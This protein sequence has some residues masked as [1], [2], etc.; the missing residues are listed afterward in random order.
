MQ[1]CELD[2]TTLQSRFKNARIHFTIV[3]TDPFTFKGFGLCQSSGALACARASGEGTIKPSSPPRAGKAVG[4]YRSPRRSVTVEG[5]VKVPPVLGLRQPSD[6][7]ACAR[8]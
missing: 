5:V 1:R 6:D 2:R 4:D 7:W 8:A 3:G